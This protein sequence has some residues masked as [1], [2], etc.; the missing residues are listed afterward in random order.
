M[1]NRGG[2]GH[3]GA[4]RGRGGG[5]RSDQRQDQSS[6][7]VA[8]PG[9]QQSYGGRG[10]SVSAGRGRGNVGR[11]ENT[12]D[13]TATQVPVASAV[14]GGRGRG[15]I[16][17]PTFSVAS[18]S[19]TVSVA[20]SSK[21]ESKNTEV[22]ET[23]SNL[24]ITSTETKPEMTSLPPASSKAVTFPVRPGRGT[25]GKKVMVRAN[26]FL[27]Q[28]ADRD[29][30]HYDVSFRPFFLDESVLVC[31]FYVSISNIVVSISSSYSVFCFLLLFSFCKPCT[32]KDELFFVVCVHL[33]LFFQ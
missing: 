19:K 17:D 26:H 11:G 32:S 5:R 2:G 12:G 3:G 7:Q 25:L 20:S 1:S 16:G 22:S 24:Q 6:G 14:S 33:K 31:R 15:N 23:M 18:S 13:L 4:S 28:V 30:Y 27:V 8:W 21:E 9:L 29:L 10:G